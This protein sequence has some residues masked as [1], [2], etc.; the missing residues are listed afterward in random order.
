M[1]AA[2]DRRMSPPDFSG[3][4]I[5]ATFEAL[6]S[7][8]LTGF[9][10]LLQEL[11]L[12]QSDRQGLMDKHGL[13]NHGGAV[14]Y[15]CYVNALEAAAEALSCPDL[16]MRLAQWQ[17]QRA[18]GPL[19]RVMRHSRTIGD[20]LAFVTSHTYAHSLAANI[21]MRPL[22]NGDS[23]IGHDIL[24]SGLPHRSQAMEHMLLVGHLSMKAMTQG[25]VQPRKIWFRHVRNSPQSVYRK[26]FGCDVSFERQADG[27]VLPVSALTFPIPS[28]NDTACSRDIDFIERMFQRTRPP[29]HADV[30]GF[31]MHQV[32]QP[33]CN[34][35]MVAAQLGL[36]PRT[37][38]R[39]L[40]AEGTSFQQ[41]KDEVR[42][43]LFL[44]LLKQPDRELGEIAQALGFAEQS[45][46][47]RRCRQWF[48]MSPLRVRDH[49]LRQDGEARVNA[50]DT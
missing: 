3:N 42:Q 33:D 11:G 21:W 8:L 27:L 1:E 40:A 17:G 2:L 10:D 20:A 50:I 18:I 35:P 5:D 45:V 32:D 36:H 29:L 19:G 15:R 23:F 47:A 37:L 46:L 26:Y 16:G 34:L 9:G 6:N 25:F 39:K 12:D 41:I 30:R 28:P 24:L 43:D 4:R 49:L 13:P 31:C 44:Y 22:L 48:G 14:S 7:D 38:N